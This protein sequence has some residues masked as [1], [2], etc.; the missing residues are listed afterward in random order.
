MYQN[1]YNEAMDRISPSAAQ[2]SALKARLAQPQSAPAPR[3]KLWPRL[4]AAA[5][6]LVFLGGLAATQFL[7][8]QP[9]PGF[10]V[11]AVSGGETYDLDG[12]AAVIKNGQILP[13]SNA[14]FKIYPT[15]FQVAGKNIKSVT[16]SSALA[17]Q[18]DPA[19]SP[20]EAIY[21]AVG[22]KVYYGRGGVM[23]L[24]YSGAVEQRYPGGSFAGGY[25]Y[26]AQMDQLSREI[27]TDGR[28]P[29]GVVDDFSHL[30]EDDITLIATFKDGH[31]EAQTYHVALSRDGIPVITRAETDGSD[32]NVETEPGK[33]SQVLL[34]DGA[35]LSL[36]FAPIEIVPF[37]EEKVAAGWPEYGVAS[38]GVI[39]HFHGEDIES[40]TYSIPHVAEGPR[41]ENHVLPTM[42]YDV[43][44]N[45]SWPD[46]E[47][48]AMRKEL[49]P[50]TGH[51]F[52]GNRP[53]AE[54]P[55][56]ITV[57]AFPCSEEYHPGLVC[58]MCAHPFCGSFFHNSA[59]TQLRAALDAGQFP[60]GVVDDFSFL[61][62]ETVSITVNFK[63]GRTAE[64]TYE[65]SYAKDGTPVV[66]SK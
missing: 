47:T 21:S 55:D 49:A 60:G 36:E 50:E 25:C 16:F 9:A 10:T 27:F 45:P 23:T 26:R 48:A 61:E 7:G 31:T 53:L 29:D 57:R 8:P 41:A 64:R 19:Q 39:F 43:D 58:G 28:W 1:E 63:D 6:A 38:G 20:F 42:M 15:V 3:R 62:P 66:I 59:A 17:R 2:L 37:S 32:F 34:L 46:P 44:A 56:S 35:E 54:Y 5:L 24:E 11:Q 33:E 40:V 51:A 14:S 65:I 4:V 12:S 52:S 22:R 30:P 18:N 13:G